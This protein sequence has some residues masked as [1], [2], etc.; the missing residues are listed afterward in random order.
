MYRVKGGDGV[1]YGPA[2]ADQI[3]QWL[4]DGRLNSQSLIAAVGTEEWRPLGSYPELIPPPPNLGGATP[5]FVLADSAASRA[6]ADAIVQ[7][8]LSREKRVEVFG[9]LSRAWNLYLQNFWPLLGVNSLGLVLLIAA[10][11][12]YAGLLVNSVIMAGL[13]HH[14]LKLIR[15]QPVLFEDMFAGFTLAFVP[16]LLVSLVSG[17]LTVVGF[18]LCVIPGIYLTVIWG[19]APIIVL[20]KRLQFWDAMEVSRKV[21]HRHFWPLL[22]LAALC[23]LLGLLGS[24][25]VLV[26]AFFVF[27]I[28]I[29]AWMYAYEDIF[30]T[31]P[32]P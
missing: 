24:L 16:L 21:A 2:S 5:P 17:V 14:A 12:V 10:N 7:E 25:V 3:R 19:F 13:F 28:T 23:W 15:R 27:P 9:S 20:E 8:V 32:A 1:E 29:V 11:S 4:R 6:A 26:G 18:F 31:R 22:G 30:G